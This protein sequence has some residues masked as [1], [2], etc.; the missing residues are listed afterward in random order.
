MLHTAEHK[1][2]LLTKA[3][4]FSA[5]VL[6]PYINICRA[7]TFLLLGIVALLIVSKKIVTDYK[8]LLSSLPFLGLTTLYVLVIAS[9]ISG[10]AATAAY[11]PVEQKAA[12]IVVLPAFYILNRAVPGSWTF[13]IKGFTAGCLLAAIHCLTYAIWSFTSDGQPTAFSY[14]RYAAPTGLSAIYCSLY[15]MVAILYLEHMLFNEQLSKKWRAAII[16]MFTFLMLNLL[17][18]S[19]KMLIVTGLG[20]ILL[21]AIR[22]LQSLKSKLL[23]I[24]GCIVLVVALFTTHNPVQKRFSELHTSSYAAA[25]H[26]KDFSRFEF[27]GLSLRLLLWRMGYEM[28]SE[29]HAWAVGLGD[30]HYEA[31]LQDKIM[32]YKMYTGNGRTADTGFL[33][34]NMHNQYM[35]TLVQNGLVGLLI[36][37]AL[38]GFW[39]HHSYTTNSTFLFYTTLLFI[40]SFTTESVLETQSGILLF[41]II[42]SGAWTQSPELKNR[43][44]LI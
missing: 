38:L 31:R 9:T 42:T 22:Q 34:Y 8:P 7:S 24:A 1:L 18:L 5:M 36:L 29:Q 17:L 20:I 25:L 13:A 6:L 32:H 11:N 28:L 21:Q 43:K 30:K 39:L 33:H 40:V 19:S 14:H 41:T 3:L 35:Q 27:D 12:L 2:S 15:F 37:L 26:E 44:T 16:C 10:H 23:A 4:L